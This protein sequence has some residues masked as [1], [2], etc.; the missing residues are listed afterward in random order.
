M[1]EPTACTSDAGSLVSAEEGCP[2]AAWSGSPDVDADDP[3]PCNT[4]LVSELDAQ[5][6]TASLQLLSPAAGDGDCRL[7]EGT[8]PDWP[9][10]CKPRKELMLLSQAYVPSPRRTGT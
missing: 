7:P 2:P 5:T 4:V 6:S 8:A 9:F 1:Y 3:E 10:A